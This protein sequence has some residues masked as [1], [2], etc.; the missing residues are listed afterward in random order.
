MRAKLRVGPVTLPQYP[1][2]PHADAGDRTL[3]IL[4]HAGFVLTGVVNTMI[5]PLLPGL[6]LRWSL[7]DAQAGLLFTAQ[8]CGSIFGVLASSLLVARWGQRACLM[9]GLGSMA[10]G[11]ATLLAGDWRLS[12]L[13]AFLMGFGLGLTIPTTNFLISTL[14][15]ERR[16]AALNLINF[17]WGVGAVVCPFF[18]ALLLR[19]HD[20]TLFLYGIS[21]LLL[22]V[23]YSLT[24]VRIPSSSPASIPATFRT[25]NLWRSPWIPILGALFFLYVGSEGSVS[26]WIATY[27]KRMVVGTRTIWVLVPSLFWAML[28]LGRAVAPLF[29]RHI[30]ELRLAQLGVGLSV[31]GIVILLAARN[32]ST[33]A[34]GVTIAG[35]GFS[36][37]FPIIIA[38]L[39]RTFGSK[40][41]Q[42][43]GVM[44]A[45]AG[46]GGATLPWLAG[47]VSTRVGGLRFGL[48]VPLLGCIVMLA[49]NVRLAETE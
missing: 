8:F 28:L 23:M 34:I 42:V 9:L 15:P 11:S 14:N 5:G 19:A 10:L 16:A 38:S 33:L 12:I 44:F 39:G 1:F 4:L 24:S 7:S 25:P 20:T 27:A 17:S 48:A 30:K 49:L 36:S 3:T 6:S 31:A 13:S 29:L 40:E 2:G 37:V 21:A 46:C 45:L 43:A 32:L 41:S 35:L 18:L 22:I 26:G 47:F